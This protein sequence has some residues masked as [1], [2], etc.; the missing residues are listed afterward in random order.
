[1]KLFFLIGLVLFEVGQSYALLFKENQIYLKTSFVEPTETLAPYFDVPLMIGL[2]AK[3]KYWKNTHIDISLAGTQA[4]GVVRNGLSQEDVKIA[5]IVGQT[6]FTAEFEQLLV[7]SLQGGLS[8]H[9]VK[10]EES[11]LLLS[12]GESDFGYYAG[13]EVVAFEKGSFRLSPY[14]EL[15]QAWTLPYRSYFHLLGVQME[16]KL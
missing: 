15:L 16:F 3:I 8:L 10:A 6:G 4:I 5:W 2:G 12:S 1:M 14:Y 11:K 9:F 7:F 13:F